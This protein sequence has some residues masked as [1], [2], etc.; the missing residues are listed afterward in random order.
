MSVGENFANIYLRGNAWQKY[1]KRNEIGA[2]NPASWLVN[3][4][5]PV[6]RSSGVQ[7]PRDICTRFGRYLYTTKCSWIIIS[8]IRMEWLPVVNE[9]VTLIPENAK[10]K[11]VGQHAQI[12]RQKFVAFAHFIKYPMKT[13]CDRGN[14][15]TATK[16]CYIISRCVT[17][18]VYHFQEVYFAQSCS[19][20]V[21]RILFCIHV[22]KFA[23]LFTPP[24]TS[25]LPHMD[26]NGPPAYPPLPCLLLSFFL[27]SSFASVEHFNTVVY[28]IYSQPSG[29]H[30]KPPHT[31]HIAN[32]QH[33]SYI[34]FI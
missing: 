23:L 3:G 12:S 7:I 15:L 29:L 18:D 11:M 4:R 14:R 5:K 30:L 26:N 19:R 32:N 33:T 34:F 24:A 1:A 27:H 16:L 6:Y 13:N 25:F 2:G 22:K 10:R 28:I 17:P 9:M 8:A 21:P 31:Q 20:F